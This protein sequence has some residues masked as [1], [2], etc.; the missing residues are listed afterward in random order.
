MKK[1]IV[2]KSAFSL[3]AMAT[4]LSVTGCQT[5]SHT[6]AGT[7][8]NTAKAH[9]MLANTGTQSQMGEI[10]LRP[11]VGGVQVYGKV[12]GLKPNSVHAIHIHEKPDCGN[13]GDAA[14]GH[15]NPMKQPHG[16]PDNPNSPS[17]QLPNIVADSNGVAKINFINTRLSLDPNSI[18]SAYNHPIVV[19]SGIDDYKSQPSGNAGGRIACGI[20]TPL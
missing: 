9:A 6:L 4:V 18:L 1:S 5:V 17:G 11:V 15:F 8:V 2:K 14:G 20:I 12:T 3:L 16:Y 13:G 7:P 10:M 19:H